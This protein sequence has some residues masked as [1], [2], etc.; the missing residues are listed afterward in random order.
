M[1]SLDGKPGPEGWLLAQRVSSRP[2]QITYYLSNALQST[3]VIRLAMIASSRA[4]MGRCLEEA[5]REVGLADYEVRYW[6]SWYRHIT[7]A[8]LAYAW[9]TMRD[10][11]PQTLV[12]SHGT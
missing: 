8:M 10:D 2:W 5:Q 7:L 4:T 6:H 12:Q 11:C 9:Q 1:E 3:S